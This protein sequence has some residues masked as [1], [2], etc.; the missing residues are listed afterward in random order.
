M[1]EWPPQDDSVPKEE[2]AAEKVKESSN[3]RQ[4][5]SARVIN[6]SIQRRENFEDDAARLKERIAGTTDFAALYG[7]INESI[8]LISEISGREMTADGLIND[9]EDAVTAFKSSGAKDAEAIRSHPSYGTI[10]G[11]G[12]I[13]KH[14]LELVIGGK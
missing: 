13:R 2:V 10:T 12:G 5:E 9:I 4:I 8:A 1:N 11:A 3:E 7:E 14:V 6:E